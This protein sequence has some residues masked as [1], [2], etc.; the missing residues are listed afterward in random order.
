MD[1]ATLLSQLEQLACKLGVEVRYESFE[2]EPGNCA[3]GSCRVKGKHLVIVNQNRPLED[4]VEVLRRALKSFDL[5]NIYIRPALRE[6]L[7]RQA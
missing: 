5:E 3:G 2:D 1:T 6:Y 7:C 4:Q